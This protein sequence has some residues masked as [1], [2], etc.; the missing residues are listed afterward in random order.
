MTRFLKSTLAKAFIKASLLN[1]EKSLMY[2]VSL[3]TGSLF[4]IEQKKSV[5]GQKIK[6][7]NGNVKFK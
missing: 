4:A 6:S 3:V 7:L 1:F 2:L 5:N